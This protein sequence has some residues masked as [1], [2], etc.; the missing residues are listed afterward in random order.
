MRSLSFIWCF[1]VCAQA[2][3]KKKL[4]VAD[5]H[6][7]FLPFLEDINKQDHARSYATRALFFL[8]KENT[9]KVLALELALPPK[10]PGGPLN[11]RVFLPP[12]G[13]SK[14]DYVWE[15]AKAHVSNND[16]SA[17]QVFSHL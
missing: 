8:S 17:H 4:Y 7:S 11:S 15:A 6:D 2:V 1:H 3:S 10:T 16:I 9:L 14:V 5:Y 13:T 12:T